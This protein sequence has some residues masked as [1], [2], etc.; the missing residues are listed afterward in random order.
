[1]NKREK[2][3]AAAFGLGAVACVTFLGV[4]RLFLG[5]AEKC[6]QD[7]RELQTQIATLKAQIDKKDAYEA[8][9]KE[10]FGAAFGVD[11]GRPSEQ[12]RSRVSE[13][14]RTTVDHLL[15]ASGL[16]TRNL[17]LKPMD[18]S[19]SANVYRELGWGVRATGKLEHVIN[20]LYLMSREP[21]LHRL[22][23]VVLSPSA[24]NPAEVELQVK[25]ATLIL[26][27]SKDETLASDTL[28]EV[29]LT[30]A[31]LDSEERRQYDIIAARDLFRPFIKRPPQVAVRVAPP[32]VSSGG[33]GPVR[34]SSP[35][36]ERIMSLSTYDGQ[37][38][39]LLTTGGKFKVGD[40]LAG[41][42]IVRVDVRSLPS[43]GNPEVPSPS[44][45]ILRIAS[46]YYAVELGQ[47]LTEKRPL[48][49][50]DLPPDLPP[51]QTVDPG[52]TSAPQPELKQPA[53][54]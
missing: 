46:D 41:G 3:L 50:A 49:A 30:A 24:A 5:P 13:R 40:T 51:L 12:V 39:I 44:R 54:K 1:M 19:A 35:P 37:A 31:A 18:G 4:D 27:K 15:T 10:L 25:Y 28:P 16:S 32:E 7:A 26:A 33:G 43:P 2:I 6:D 45:V 22:D 23:N 38:D 11:E 21:H 9:L 53:L 36:A 29:T 20:F 8:R 47:A 52:P 14:V 48:P 17:S 34:T 42:K